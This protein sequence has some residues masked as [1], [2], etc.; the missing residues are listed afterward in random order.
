MAAA[1]ESKT[2]DAIRVILITGAGRGFCAGADLSGGGPASNGRAAPVQRGPFTDRT[3]PGRLIATLADADVPIIGA[4]NGAATGAGFGLACC[5]DVRIVS[6]QARMGTIFIKRGLSTDYGTSHWLPRIVGLAKAYDLIY[7][8][9]LMDAA[10]LLAVGLAN[11][12]VP[13]ESLMAEALAYA[14]RI[15]AGPPLAYTYV[16]RNITRS[17]DQEIHGNLELEWSHQK[18]LLR[19]TDAAEGFKAFLEKRAPSFTGA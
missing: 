19:T 2:N 13:H 18:E 4:I 10:A 14:G 6:D 16:R 8:G 3:G 1:L 12:V 5:C 15:A 7:T 9:E 17:L 11:R